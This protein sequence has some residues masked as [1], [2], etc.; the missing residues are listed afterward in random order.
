MFDRKSLLLL[1]SRSTIL[2]FAVIVAVVIVAE[3]V[4]LIP[5]SAVGLGLAIMLFLREQIGGAVVRRKLYGNEMFSKQVRLPEEMAVLEQRGDRIVIFELQGSLF[6]GTTDQLYSALEPELKNKDRVYFILDMRR[7]QSVDVTAAH[8]LENIEHILRERGGFLIFSHLPLNV[9]TGQHLEDY[10]DQVG[11]VRAERRVRTFG[12]RDEA[13]EW[14]EDNILGEASLERV[15]EQ[16]LDLRD[17]ELFKAR[18]DETLAALAACMETGS[19]KA[20]QTIFARGDAGDSLFLIRRGT[21]RIMLPLSGRTPYHLATFSRGDFFG[22]MAFLD[23]ETRSADAVAVG[24]TEVFVLS[25][26][27]FDGLAQQ[28]QQLALSLLE[29]LARVLAARMRHTD[30]EISALQDS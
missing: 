8:M 20:G 2:D 14:V 9:P 12:H 22:E 18:T 30:R 7:V 29:S 25:R 16:P 6:F 5:A 26:A 27:R 1:R 21:V 24:D 23:R 3:T 17:I 19:Y 15:H 11:L 28:H 10:F 4:G 13:L